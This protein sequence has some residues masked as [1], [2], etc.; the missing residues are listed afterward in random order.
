MATDDHTIKEE[1]AEVSG[2]TTLTR[3]GHILVQ[4]FNATEAMVIAGTSEINKTLA[5][6]A[7]AHGIVNRTSK[8]PKQVHFDLTTKLQVDKAFTML[9][10][11]LTPKA[12]EALFDDQ[13][14]PTLGT[15]MAAGH[16]CA[17][18]AVSILA[19][20]AWMRVSGTGVDKTATGGGSGAAEM[21][22]A[23]PPKMKADKSGAV[24]NA[25]GEIEFYTAQKVTQMRAAH[26]KQ[27]SDMKHAR[28]RERSRAGGG[29]GPQTS[30]RSQQPYD[31]RYDE[32]QY[33]ARRERPK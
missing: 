3:N 2:T 18:A 22:T 9:S 17:S 10:G 1:N 24:R 26:E 11:N 33:E 4:I 28:E 15:M 6:Y 29:S 27:V 5:H 14:V 30:Y 7:G 12:L 23:T 13:F 20:A 31:A 8:T 16:S 32:P 21:A 25:S 19:N